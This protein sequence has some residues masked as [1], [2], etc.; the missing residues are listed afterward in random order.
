M[1]VREVIERL[2]TADLDKEVLI[3]TQSGERGIVS[4]IT[5]YDDEPVIIETVED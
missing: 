4:V 5:H 3:N 2:E 1:T